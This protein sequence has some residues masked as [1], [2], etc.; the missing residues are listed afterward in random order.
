MKKTWIALFLA[1]CMLTT[2]SAAFACCID[3]GCASPS[4]MNE[5]QTMEET[6]P[7]MMDGKGVNGCPCMGDVCGEDCKCMDGE[8]CMKD[9]M[10]MDGCMCEEEMCACG[11]DCDCAYEKKLEM[12]GAE[13]NAV[14][15]ANM[16]L[17]EKF[18][19]MMNKQPDMDMNYADYLTEELEMMKEKF[20]EEEYGMLQQDIETIRGIDEQISK[21]EEMYVQD[22]AMTSNMCMTDGQC[23]PE[24]DC[25]ADACTGDCDCMKDKM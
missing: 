16:D 20:T 24:C 11:D 12:L 4:G 1:L 10:C 17:W 13:M 8:S 7:C 9:G 3:E 19:G 23:A 15:E 2:L 5:A 14:F 6:C 25:E 21:L 18:F 22:E